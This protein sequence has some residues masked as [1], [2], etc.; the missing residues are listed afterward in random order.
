MGKVIINETVCGSEPVL[1]VSFADNDLFP[2]II[3]Y[4]MAQ[5]LGAALVQDPD[6]LNKFVGRHK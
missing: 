6:F 1:Q 5:R 2:V 4:H 3:G